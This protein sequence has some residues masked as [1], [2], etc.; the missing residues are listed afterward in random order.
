[1]LFYGG[2]ICDA[3]FSKCCGGLTE[4]LRHRLGRPGDPLPR[5]VPRRPDGARSPT[6]S[7]PSSARARRPS[8]TRPTRPCSPASSPA[9]TRRRATSSA[10]PSRTRPKSWASCPLR[11][12]ASTSDRSSRL[13]PLARGPSGRIFR[14][15]ITG[16]RG[17]LVVGKE[18]EIRRAL[19]SLA[20]LQLGVRRRPRRGG[21]L[22]PD[23][24]GLGARRRP[25]PDRGGGDGGAGIRLPRDPRA[26]LPG[27]DGRARRLNLE[28]RP[29]EAA[30]RVEIRPARVRSGNSGPSPGVPCCVGGRR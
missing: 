12:S 29:P 22:R 6:T 9:S 1:M 8:A 5:L 30:P 16:E 23:R 11:A 21:P 17:T 24:R 10:G 18:L 2:A 28:S 26:L 27:D 19:S 3:R 15:R 4:A 7:T 13:E 14:L 20:P 25:L